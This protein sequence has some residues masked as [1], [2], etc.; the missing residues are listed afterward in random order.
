MSQK[1]INRRRLL[2]SAG[3]ITA[4][5]LLSACGDSGTPDKP[6]KLL[7]RLKSF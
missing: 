3:L 4:A 7:L 1:K 2:K 5:G 6:G